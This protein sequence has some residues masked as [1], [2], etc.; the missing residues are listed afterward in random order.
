MW[1]ATLTTAESDQVCKAPES[2]LQSLA[3]AN[4]GHPDCLLSSLLMTAIW[5]S[6]C[7]T[8]FSCYCW[9]RSGLPS[10]ATSESSQLRKVL[11]SPL[12]SLDTGDDDLDS[13]EIS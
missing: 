10:L 5:S 7:W 3:P 8:V 2:Q 1:T 9:G 13:L 6:R 11:E 12:P 4:D